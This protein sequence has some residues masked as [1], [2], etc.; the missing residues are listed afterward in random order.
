MS[1]SKMTYAG[2]ASLLRRPAI[3]AYR[4]ISRETPNFE[5]A[6][7]GVGSIARCRYKRGQSPLIRPQCPFNCL[8]G[9]ASSR[10]FWPRVD[11]KTNLSAKLSGRYREDSQGTAFGRTE[12]FPK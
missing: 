3:T 2:I 7:T 5:L 12:T 1:T 11:L 9:Q 6:D 8:S 10:P 4:L